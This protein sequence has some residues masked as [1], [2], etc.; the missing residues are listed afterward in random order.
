M[1]IHVKKK[2]SRMAGM[3]RVVFWV[4]L[5]QLR[6][7]QLICPTSS[8]LGAMRPIPP[9]GVAMLIQCNSHYH[10]PTNNHT[11]A[12]T[13]QQ[14]HTIYNITFQCQELWSM[15]GLSIE[16]FMVN[17]KKFLLLFTKITKVYLFRS[18]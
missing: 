5:I 15:Q 10:T 18:K 9:E 2:A 12:K 1:V 3:G 6:C 13:I 16:L 4:L 7:H 17:T 14:A 8:V 11:G